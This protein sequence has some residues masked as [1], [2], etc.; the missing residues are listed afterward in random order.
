MPSETVET[1]EMIEY[2]VKLLKSCSFLVNRVEHPSEGKRLNMGAV[3]PRGE[4]NR[5]AA[6]AYRQSQAAP[7]SSAGRWRW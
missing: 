6:S 4:R 1:V 7:G 5:L 3:K 2:G